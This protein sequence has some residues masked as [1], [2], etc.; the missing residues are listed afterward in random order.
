MGGAEVFVGVLVIA[1]IIAFFVGVGIG[2]A[3]AS[4]KRTELEIDLTHTTSTAAKLEAKLKALTRELDFAS[5]RMI[6]LFDENRI[7][8]G[9]MESDDDIPGEGCDAVRAA[10]RD[11]LRDDRRA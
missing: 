10:P 7:L 11:E 5:R 3:I 8:R 4:G 1:V 6:R 9:G 2:G